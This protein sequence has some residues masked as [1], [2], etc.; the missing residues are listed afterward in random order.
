MMI[1][2]GSEEQEWNDG[3]EINEDRIAKGWTLTC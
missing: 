3:Y 2:G 1:F